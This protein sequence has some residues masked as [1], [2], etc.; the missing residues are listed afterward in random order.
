MQLLQINHL[1]KTRYPGEIRDRVFV[2]GY[3]YF[4]FA[5]NISRN[6]GKTLSGTYSQRLHDHAKKSATDLIKTACKIVSQKKAETT[7]W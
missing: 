1:E 4:S 7:N 2:K 5:K 3:A 6:V